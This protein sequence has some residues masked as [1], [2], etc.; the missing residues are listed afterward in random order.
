MRLGGG[1][2]KKEIDELFSAIFDGRKQEMCDSIK[3]ELRLSAVEKALAEVTEKLTEL[4]LA[5]SDP[6]PKNVK[7]KR[8]LKFTEEM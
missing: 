5:Q 8:V 6:V 2:F 4:E 1:S 7:G 3:T